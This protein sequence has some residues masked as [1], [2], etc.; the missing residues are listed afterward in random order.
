MWRAERF[1]YLALS[2]IEAE[3]APKQFQ[4]ESGELMILPDLTLYYSQPLLLHVSVQFPKLATRLE[5]GLKQAKQDAS[6]NKLLEQHSIHDIQQMRKIKARVF[7]LD[8]PA[9]SASLGLDKPVLLP[10]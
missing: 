5:T 7:V 1:D 8:N 6:L 9:V 10:Q 2:V 4:Q 3:G